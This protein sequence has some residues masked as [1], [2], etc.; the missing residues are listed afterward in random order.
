MDKLEIWKSYQNKYFKNNNPTPVVNSNVSQIG[1]G[2]P[3]LQPTPESRPVT[4]ENNFSAINYNEKITSNQKE[5]ADIDAKLNNVVMK[6]DEL[7]LIELNKISTR[8]NVV[9]TKT[10][11]NSNLIL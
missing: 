1:S 11:Q 5:I 9:Q 2:D 4:S 7:K 3:N 10:I 8:Q 6:K